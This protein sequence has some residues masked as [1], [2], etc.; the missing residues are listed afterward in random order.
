M[1]IFFFCKIN[2]GSIPQIRRETV[3]FKFFWVFLLITR[4]CLLSITL[5]GYIVQGPHPLELV[6]LLMMVW[7]FALL[8]FMVP[9]SRLSGIVRE[10]LVTWQSCLNDKLSSYYD[11]EVSIGL[12]LSM[13]Q[14]SRVYVNL[15]DI[16]GYPGSTMVHFCPHWP[17]FFL[18][19]THLANPWVFLCS[20]PIASVGCQAR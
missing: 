19:S 20:L 7:I 5:L 4:T 2:I 10:R 18:L 9:R 13:V 17:L 3:L 14:G 8:L 11:S 1:I 16:L 12:I 6:L 15:G